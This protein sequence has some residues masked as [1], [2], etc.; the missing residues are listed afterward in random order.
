[1]FE[2]VNPA[3][4]DKLAD[5]IAGALV[6]MAYQNVSSPKIAV[7]VLLGHDTCTVIAETSVHI[8][9]ADVQAVVERIADITD[10]RYIEVPQDA[11]LADNQNGAVRCGDNGI[12]RGCPLTDEQKTLSRI[13]RAVYKRYPYDGK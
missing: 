7:E 6:D 9:D 5:R 11:H 13:A 4:A 3:H 2:K 10:V 8:P 12:F 1:M